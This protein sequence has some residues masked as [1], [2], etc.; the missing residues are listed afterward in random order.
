MGLSMLT[1]IV[2]D[3]QWMSDAVPTD[4]SHDVALFDIAPL[5]QHYGLAVLG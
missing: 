4:A 3:D 1:N 2:I 5:Q